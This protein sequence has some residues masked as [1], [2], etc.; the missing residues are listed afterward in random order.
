MITRKIVRLMVGFLTL[1]VVVATWAAPAPLITFYGMI[2]DEFG[3][4]CEGAV[5]LVFKSSG[6]VVFSKDLTL[7][8]G[9]DYNY[10][11]RVPYDTGVVDYSPASIAMGDTVTAQVIAGDGTLL[12]EKTM[13]VDFP[14]GAVINLNASASTDSQGDGIP[15]ALRRWIWLCLD[16]PGPFDP[17]TI[18]ASMDSDGDGVSNLA[19]YLAGTDPANPFD[20]LKLNITQA[21]AGQSGLVSSNIPQ[22]YWFSVPGKTYRVEVGSIGA[23]AV[24][25]APLP[26]ASSPN[27][28]ST[29]SFQIG[30]GDYISAF[31]PSCTTNSVFRLSVQSPANGVRLVR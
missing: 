17:R 12:A 9:R 22:L 20:Y 19:E 14:A 2:T 18:T 29:N 27:G 6:A 26:F 28:D 30:I 31:A 1:S 23:G 4:P 3:W 10:I 5:K 11:V 16:V 21:L 24:Q 25:W 13:T 7:A 15:D 8:R